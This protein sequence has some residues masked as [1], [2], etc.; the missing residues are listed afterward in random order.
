MS[1]QNNKLTDTLNKLYHIIKLREWIKS[2]NT[3]VHD[4]P[5]DYECQEGCRH[6]L[7]EKL[8]NLCQGD[9]SIRDHIAR[10]EDLTY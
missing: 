9:L 6:R 7:L 1:N 10:F 5:G 2:Q 8:H 4:S 3:K